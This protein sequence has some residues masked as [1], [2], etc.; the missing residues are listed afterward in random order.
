[1][2]IGDANPNLDLPERAISL[3]CKS[4]AELAEV[5]QARSTS[6]PVFFEANRLK[7]LESSESEGIA[8]RLWYN[9]R[10]GLAVAYGTVDPQVLVDKAIA[11]SALNEPET[12]ELADGGVK[13]FPNLGSSIAIEKL[14][15]MGKEA[16]ALVRDFCPDA[17][18]STQWD[19][20]SE[21]TRLLTSKGLD[22]SYTDTTLSAFLSAELVRGDDFL[23][24]GDGQTQ[25]DFLSPQ[26]IAENIIKRLDWAKKNVR[27]RPGK[28]PVLFT[29]KA[30]DLLWDTVQAAL[31]GKQVIEGASPW[32]NA[33]GTPVV[34]SL[35]T[36]SQEPD[37]G[38]YSC[39]FDD[40]GMLTR[41]LTFIDRGRLQM[42]YADRTVGKKL[43]SGSTGCGFRPGLGSYPM[44]GLAN[45]TIVPANVDFDTLIANM[46][47][48]IIIDQVLGGS[49]GISGNFSIE[50]DLGYRVSKGEIIGRIKDTMV[51]GNVYQALKNIISLGSD[52]DWNG[53]CATP[54]IVV[55]SLS[56]TSQHV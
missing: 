3:A 11:I 24:V 12:P 27:S 30:A 34:S 14:I 7:Q 50:L 52:V 4:G 46:S 51:S 8:L 13:E 25:R 32:N 54:S 56:I 19:C 26:Y 9:G 33:I 5:Y 29:A 49:A 1:M 21:T 41:N 6:A 39:P 40:E 23:N 48:G 20:E 53:P 10:P 17:I 45:L 55:D 47:E 42:F 35:L 18:C 37:I 43:G 44:P 38:P 15:E 31:N 22:W 16:I 28:L 36:I 2:T